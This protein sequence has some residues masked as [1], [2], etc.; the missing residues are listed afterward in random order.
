MS[1]EGMMDSIDQMATQ[2]P[3]AKMLGVDQATVSH[4]LDESSSKMK[5]KV[6]KSLGKNE[7]FD[8]NSSPPFLTQS[9]AEI[10]KQA[11]K[12]GLKKESKEGG[13]ENGKLRIEFDGAE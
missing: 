2:R 10:L 4:D 3:I 5:K 13:L 9:G 7:E 12:L 6:L 8:E 1:K 11:E